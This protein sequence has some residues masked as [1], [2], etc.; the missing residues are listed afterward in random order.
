MGQSVPAGFPLS[1]P[2]RHRP[3]TKGELSKG[4][5]NRPAGNRGAGNPVHEAVIRAIPNGRPGPKGMGP[6]GPAAR[7][8][9]TR[10]PEAEDGPHCPSANPHRKQSVRSGPE[11]GGGAPAPHTLAAPRQHASVF[12][13]TKSPIVPPSGESPECVVRTPPKETMIP[14]VHGS[15]IGRLTAATALLWLWVAPAPA[16]ADA[17]AVAVV[18]Q[19]G[20]ATA[21]SA[22]GDG[23][24]TPP[25]APPPPPSPEPSPPPPSP[26]PP[27]PPPAPT[28][29]PPPPEPPPPPKPSPPAPRAAPRPSPRPTPPPPAP[30]PAPPPAP[31]PSPSPPPSPTPS[32]RP[33]PSVV[34]LPA[35][36]RPHRQV[37][38]SGTSLVTLTL[39]ITAPAVFAVAVLRPRSSR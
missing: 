32:A 35:Y 37:H 18:G 26:A 3:Y 10:A 1:H 12:R 27:P 13:T 28:P 5:A 14:V 30:V 17:C 29:A 20:T 7:R 21:V 8:R 11:A 33:V 2:D 19:D 39:M 31:A 16:V 38:D 9:R 4:E 23:G 6:A 22:A 24:C 34:A 36:R 15:R 25:P